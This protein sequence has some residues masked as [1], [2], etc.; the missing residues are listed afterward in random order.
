[1]KPRVSEFRRVPST[2]T[3][4]PPSTVTA[5]LQA[6][7][8]SSGHALRTVSMRWLL[9]ER[10]SFISG[11]PESSGGFLDVWNPLRPSPH[12]DGTR[13]SIERPPSA[14]QS[15]ARPQAFPRRIYLT[16]IADYIT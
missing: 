5:R 1:M 7:G 2:E 10:L 11:A 14:I 12:S 8:Q 15:A 6:S 4:R 9:P 16:A 13:P 3:T